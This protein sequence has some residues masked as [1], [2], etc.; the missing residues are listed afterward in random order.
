MNMLR[1]YLDMGLAQ[2]GEVVAGNRNKIDWFFTMALPF[3]CRVGRGMSPGIN[4]RHGMGRAKIS[5]VRSQFMLRGVLRLT[6]SFKDIDLPNQIGR[7]RRI[8][9][10]TNALQIAIEHL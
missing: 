10:P 1:Q 8:R 2:H 7:I 3:C 6:I 4:P 9:Y 5:D